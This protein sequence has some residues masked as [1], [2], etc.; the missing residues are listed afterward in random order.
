MQLRVLFSFIFC[1]FLF[2]GFSQ[3]TVGIIGTAT[4][5]GWDNDTDMVQHPDSAHLWSL[6]INLVQGEAKFR[7]D[8]AWDVN[9]GAPDFPSGL[10][11]AGGPNIP[12]PAPGEF[13]IT[14]NS[15]TGAYSFSVRSDIGIIGNA[16]PGGWDN[17]TNM[18]QDQA[19]TN[20]YFITLVLV[21]GEAK[22]RQNDAW[23]INW[24]AI[25]FPSGI[26]TQ[27]GPNI[28][29]AT[30]SKYLIDFNKSTGAYSFTEIA[31]YTAIGIIGSATPGG[32]DNDTDL[33]K[34]PGN[35]DLWRVDLVLNNGEAKFRANDAWT[36]NW[37]D[38]LFP[39][40]V[41]I[42]G[43]PNIPVDSGEY[44]ITFNTATFEYQFLPIATY[45]VVSLIGDA[46]PGGWSTDTPMDQDPNDK[47][48]WRKRLIFTD[49]EAK[50]RANYAWDVNWGGSDFP[51]GV[52]ELDGANIPVT[53]G[54]YKVTFNAITGE[55]SFELLV[56]YNAV[57]IIG[58]ATVGLWDTDTD[59]FKDAVDESFWSIPSIDLVDGE[60]KFRAEDAWTVNWGLAQWPAGIG[61]QDGP[62]IPVTGGTYRVT[63]NS[64]T[65]EYAF[66]APSSTLDLLKS[67]SVAIAPNPAKDV[68][69][70]QITSDELKGDAQVILFDQMGRRVLEQNVVLQN[71]TTVNVAGLQAGAYLLHISN[72][73]YMVGKNVVIVK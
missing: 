72:G 56:I 48:I 65:G 33:N 38:T 31:E 52:A 10:G 16:T 6:V 44:R 62:N 3:T 12:I 36:Y 40:G 21:T 64:A 43:G 22:F 49:G 26:G 30:G 14:F 70:I 29:I 13:T 55:Y 17:D 28:P 25:D 23:D 41:G 67:N 18:F 37:G 15:L 59:M 45:E 47:S 11:I 2:S 69:N 42:P 32:W 71:N 1:A 19:D 54:E 53:A 39:I 50:F 66:G 68:L 35:P 4:P 61:T 57:G 27:N 58:T 24:G 60:A 51:T 46:T 5:G 9:W 7:A 73:K 34:V 8:N 63:L 20:H